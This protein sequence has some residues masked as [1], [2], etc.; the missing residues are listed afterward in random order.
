MR[1]RRNPNNKN[2]AAA[3]TD[4]MATPCESGFPVKLLIDKTSKEIMFMEAE[5][6]FVDM[7]L[8]VLRLPFGALVKL[9]SD[10]GHTKAIPSMRLLDSLQT[11]P[12]SVFT[13]SDTITNVC[14]SLHLIESPF[15]LHIA[16]PFLFGL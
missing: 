3:A 7:I 8:A 10:E 12:T 9:L 6:E 11:I 16:K 4:N 1:T 2:M 15:F 14:S 5:S 13:A